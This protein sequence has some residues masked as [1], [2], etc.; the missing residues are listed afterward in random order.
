MNYYKLKA[1]KVYSIAISLA[2]LIYFQI[3][4]PL[5]TYAQ[6]EDQ[7]TTIITEVVENGANKTEATEEKDSDSLVS[8]EL[9]L[10]PELTTITETE[11][12][13]KQLEGEDIDESKDESLLPSNENVKPVEV[14]TKKVLNFKSVAVKESSGGLAVTIES[15]GTINDYKS[16]TLKQNLLAKLPGR[17]VFDILN[18]KSPFR[19]EQTIQVNNKWISGIRHYASPDKF[20]VVIDTKNTFLNS[21]TAKSVSNG[22]LISIG[23]NEFNNTDISS[24][25]DQLIEPAENI[26]YNE[27]PNVSSDIKTDLVVSKKNK[28]KDLRPAWVD[29][30]DFLSEENGKSTITIGTTKPVEYSIVKASDRLLHLRLN[31][32]NIST[33]QKRPLIT[34]R[35]N[36]A[37]DGIWPVQTPEMKKTSIIAVE[38]REKVPYLSE[39]SD[40][41]IKL[42]FEASSVSPKTEK[43]ADIPV[44]KETLEAA[45]IK[46]IKPE[47]NESVPGEAAEVVNELSETGKKY[48][49]EKIALDFYDTDIKNVF[50]ILS[51]VSGKNFA[52]DK[53][54]SGK[55]SLSLEKPVPWDQA[56]DLV[57][58]M[59]QLGMVYE[60]D[61]IRIAPLETIKKEKELRQA[62]ILADIKAKEQQKELEPLVVEYIPINYSN[63]KTDI[64]PHL[65]KLKTK[66]RGNVSV[67]ERTNLVIITD[68][69]E[70]I[71]QAKEIVI[72]LDKVTPQVLIEARIVEAR[73]DFSREIGVSWGSAVGVQSSSQMPSAVTSGITTA[74]STNINSRVGGTADSSGSLGGTYGINS[75]IN[76]PL[77]STSAASL[78]FNFVRINGT[79]FL[80][81]AKL[82]AMEAQGDGKIISA[83]KIATLDNKE[84]IISQGLDYPYLKL[85]TS[86]NTTL[87]FKEVKLEL[88]VKPHVT[89]DNRISMVIKIKKLDIG[90]IINGNQS[91][92]TKEAETELLINDG[93]TVVIGGIIKTTKSKDV[94]FIPGLSKIPL[95]GWLFKAEVNSDNKEEL[96]IFIT[97]KIVTLEQRI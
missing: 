74:N 75:A 13:A 17:I 44:W 22:L 64:L 52:I 19:K 71:K 86:G 90:A 26:N 4:F 82:Q 78:G 2:V 24:K 93:D 70:V 10:T 41:L 69:A 83:P 25:K 55:V 87:E 33:K 57:L 68:V 43:N 5:G 42:H 28:E 67:D 46:N 11:D 77:L 18:M 40:N 80:L 60:G 7:N 53:N 59:N 97:P 35:F 92:T 94:A 51:E 32:T 72:K 34:T 31:N 48:T 49:G 54:A 21:Y 85:D 12:D 16:F 56:L 47:I 91:F 96:L 81:N 15:D 50:R 1:I 14:V 73:T 63:A 65:E 76:F 88:K 30:I 61:I 38:M 79:P 8:E 45:P 62:G 20:R 89:L 84:A 9:P 29:K 66:D 95:L 6:Q 27:K 58:K 36:S 39:Q 37:I 3:V 23:T